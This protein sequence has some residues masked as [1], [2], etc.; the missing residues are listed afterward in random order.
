MSGTVEIMYVVIK[1]VNTMLCEDTLTNVLSFLEYPDKVSLYACTKDMYTR[2][3]KKEAFLYKVS[4]VHR[5]WLDKG[6]CVIADCGKLKCTSF[7]N[8]T[9]FT[10]SNY[11]WTHSSQWK[12]VTHMQEAFSMQPP[13]VFIEYIL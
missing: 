10:L 4:L 7:I 8:G 5:P 12:R 1:S 2:R 3:T 9:P 11:C 6:K 13:D